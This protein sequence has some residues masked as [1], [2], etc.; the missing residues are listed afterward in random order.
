MIGGDSGPP[1]K[2]DLKPWEKVI[3]WAKS[4][5]MTG[6]NLMMIIVIGTGFLICLMVFCRIC[7]CKTKLPQGNDEEDEDDE[8]NQEAM[9]S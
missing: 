1:V 2:Q 8:E 3:N 4:I 9:N 7:C 5:E 6:K